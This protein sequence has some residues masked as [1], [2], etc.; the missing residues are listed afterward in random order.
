[1]LD[2]GQKTLKLQLNEQ[3]KKLEQVKVACDIDD[4][5][6]LINC[7]KKRIK[8]ISALNDLWRL[9]VDTSLKSKTNDASLAE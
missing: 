6:G 9:W 5:C 1:M 8:P 4:K 7:M 2:L 3:V